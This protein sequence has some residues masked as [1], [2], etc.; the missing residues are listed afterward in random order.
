MRQLAK[1]CW[2]GMFGDG[3][4]YDVMCVEEMPGGFLKSRHLVRGISG[5]YSGETIY[6]IDPAT[7]Q[8][9]FTYYTS[10]GAIQSGRVD[11]SYGLLRF[12][13]IRH[14][15]R[16]GTK[17]RFRGTGEVLSD[18][19]YRSTTSQWRDEE[20]Q[21]VSTVLFE[22]IECEGWAEVEAGCG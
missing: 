13:D 16:D 6:F 7:G 11:L 22:R 21:L 20:W 3:P 12:E 19:R 10:L 1:A 5:S 4:A 18:G 17:L 2:R 9:G 14:V 8:A 15:A